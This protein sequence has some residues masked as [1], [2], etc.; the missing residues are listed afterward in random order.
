M[1]MKYMQMYFSYLEPLA[2]LTDEQLGR[3]T[4]A[5]LRYGRDGTVPAFDGAESLAFK[6]MR[7]NFDRETAA[8][9]D[10]VE[11]LRVN[12]RKGGR[13]KGSK[14]PNGFCENQESQEEKEEDEEK[15]EKEEESSSK[16]EVVLS[17]SADKMMM[18]DFPSVLD[19]V[20]DAFGEV[21]PYQSG[22]LQKAC[23]SLGTDLV[24][25]IINKC[26][27]NG[28]KSY[29]YLQVALTRAQA[30]GITSVDEYNTQRMR[31]KGV[32]ADRSEPSGN[33]ILRRNIGKPIK[34]KRDD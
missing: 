9:D 18:T 25:E 16:E 22:Q 10:K 7:S 1:A 24:D 8:Y 28:A 30:K 20:R 34:L 5:I 2:D 11:R 4:R 31:D 19:K 33:D 17:A 27:V 14:K 26:L 12:G 23:E 15:E 13:P 32:I 21:S 6:F 29:A 3:V